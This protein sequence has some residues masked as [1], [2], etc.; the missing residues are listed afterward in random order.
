[1]IEAKPSFL[2]RMSLA[3][4]VL[5]NAE[6][7]VQVM[8]L[9][10]GETIE[11]PEPEPE[12]EKAPTPLLKEVGPDAALQLLGL[13]QRDGRLVDFIEEDVAGFSDTEIGAAARVVHEGCR[14]VL[15]E[16]FTIE[17]VRSEA[18]GSRVT[19]GQG[20]DASAVRLSGNVV[21]EPPFSGRLA[22]RG[23]R[24]TKVQLPKLVPEHDLGVL[25]PAEV[26]L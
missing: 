4:R 6:L 13:L 9:N 26:E 2:A 23:W 12:P 7:A 8:R 21:G 1:M 24:A 11:K 5:F 16:H 10:R 19:L 17:P 3:L 15:Q 14:K 18:E 22:H 25:A 20:F